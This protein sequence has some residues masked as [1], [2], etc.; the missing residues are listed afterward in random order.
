MKK[1]SK[2]GIITHHYIKNYGAFLQAYALQEVIQQLFQNTDVEIINYI[3]KKHQYRNLR[4][5]ILSRAESKN[6][7]K[8]FR[9]FL[10]NKM[11][12]MQFNNAGRLLRKSSR[13]RTAADINR[14]RYDVIV[15]G[16]DE[17]WNTTSVGADKIKFAVGLDCPNIV[18]YA[19]SSG[20][21]E[22]DQGIPEYV[23]IGM[24]NFKKVSVRDSQTMS[25][26]KPLYNGEIE[27]VLDP[28][29]L[30]DFDPEVRSIRNSIDFPY[31]LV[32]QC[33]LNK[34]QV[35][36]LKEYAKRNK[37]K[38]VG[39]GNHK[40]WFDLS[41]INVSPF[42]WVKLF[43]QAQYV[44]TGTFHGVIFA[45]K[46]KAKFVA[47]PTLPNR[48]EK[49]K[50]LLSLLGLTDHLLGNENADKLCDCLDREIDYK[51]VFNIIQMYKQKSYSYLED[52][53]KQ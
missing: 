42:K 38:I 14:K 23:S 5:L 19:P 30:Y 39:A 48:I 18:S 25:M 43:T 40:D 29:F 8:A 7:L 1:R 24:R 32:Y 12:I 31:I 35:I 10:E 41:L 44:I 22:P 9:V 37:L 45:I 20:Y 26:V 33:D 21:Y 16:S 52:C 49:V 46:S 47:Y 11:K 2:I 6:C 4:P 17:V 50:Y 51:N 36:L 28:T 27:I 13:C 34:Q 53:M 3:N 15:I